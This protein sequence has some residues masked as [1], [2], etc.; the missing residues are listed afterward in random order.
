LI[1]S[2]GATP[3]EQIKQILTIA[4]I[5]TG[6]RR[7]SK[8]DIPPHHPHHEKALGGAKGDSDLLDL[9]SHP[10]PAG[11][12]T[13]V[14]RT[15]QPPPALE[16]DLIDFGSEADIKDDGLGSTLMPTSKGIAAG[17]FGSSG[18]DDMRELGGSLLEAEAGS[19]RETLEQ[20]S[21]DNSILISD[22]DSSDGFEDA[23]EK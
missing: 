13:Q 21:A 3:E 4:P 9:S 20:K 23:V 2:D 1:Y 12:G 8:Y 10:Q 22:D 5:L 18:L 11:A 7:N 15:P 14:H 19:R 16:A 17:R 6:V